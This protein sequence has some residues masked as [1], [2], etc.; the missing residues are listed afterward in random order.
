MGETGCDAREPAEDVEV[1]QK[2]GGSRGAR[3]GSA[4][5][6]KSLQ[7]MT[8]LPTQANKTGTGKRREERRT[9]ECYRGVLIF[10]SRGSVSPLTRV[11]RG[12]RGNN[13]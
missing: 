10:N 5:E 11:I 8:M 3:T 12:F 7:L 9:L 1:K 13:H 2:T 6:T 4:E